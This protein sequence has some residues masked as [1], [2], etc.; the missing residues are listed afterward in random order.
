[1]PQGFALSDTVLDALR[2]FYLGKSP[3]SGEEKIQPQQPCPTII[4]M[5]VGWCVGV[6]KERHSIYDSSACFGVHRGLVE[7]GAVRAL[8]KAGRIEGRSLPLSHPAILLAPL[9][10]QKYDLLFTPGKREELL[11]SK[12]G[13]A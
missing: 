9:A 5:W 8:E 1:M 4:P 7:G 11:L 3:H 12:P 13:G 6:I 2:P 10:R